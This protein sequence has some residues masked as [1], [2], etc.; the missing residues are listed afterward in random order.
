VRV[1]DGTG[2]RVLVH[3]HIDQIH[4]TAVAI[5]EEVRDATVF[6]L[7]GGTHD[8]LGEAFGSGEGGRGTTTSRSYRDCRKVS[9][10]KSYLAALL[11]LMNE[12]CVLYFRF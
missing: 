11:G 6:I 5:T 9:N 2:A 1:V 3:A 10:C 8:G 7:P 12:S 4:A